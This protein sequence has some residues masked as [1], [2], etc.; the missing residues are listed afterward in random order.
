MGEQQQ[1]LHCISPS[2]IDISEVPEHKELPMEF[3]IDII[4]SIFILFINIIL[5]IG[6]L[7]A[8]PLNIASKLFVYLSVI[9]SLGVLVAPVNF[10][11]TQDRSIPCWL[12]TLEISF[13]LL[14]RGIGFC[15]IFLI[16]ALRFLSIWK[17]FYQREIGKIVKYSLICVHVFSLTT[18]GIIAYIFARGITILEF[19]ITQ[20]ILASFL[21]CYVFT[22]LTMNLLSKHLLEKKLKMSS[23]ESRSITKTQLPSKGIENEVTKSTANT[24]K[25]VEECSTEQNLKR[26]FN[27]SSILKKEDEKEDNND[28]G[29]PPSEESNSE[30]SIKSKSKDEIKPT[31]TEKHLKEKQQQWKKRKAVK[32]LVII[33]LFYFIL[34]F[35]FAVYIMV[36][37][38]Y[39]IIDVKGN[40]KTFFGLL[41]YG[42]IANMIGYAN[43]GANAIIYIWRNKKIKDF[44]K[45]KIRALRGILWSDK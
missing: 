27:S 8:K 7:S 26:V 38:I 9:D 33:T 20:I 42:N 10:Y 25:T 43:S 18:G 45:M 36:G 5:I 17:P 6:Q 24:V 13:E 3:T 2:G 22:I 29:I 11:L 12:I 34:F 39:I 32:T 35:P 40:L 16:C 28:D 23:I 1:T 41:K 37:G 31:I 14:N 15:I 44:Y 21:M 30:K 4:I 19:G